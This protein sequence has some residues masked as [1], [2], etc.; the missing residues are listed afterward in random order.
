MQSVARTRL[1]LAIICLGSLLAPFDTTVNTAFPVITAAFSLPLRDIQWV[2]IPFVLAQSSFA[3]IFGHLGDRFGH[4]RIF[5]LG[6]GASVLAHAAV[7]LAP[8]FPTMV[9]MRMFQ[10]A[11]VGIAVSCGPALA[12]LLYAPADKARV[13]SLYIAVGSVA[14]AAGP[15]LGGLLIQTLGWPGVYWFR[16]PVALVALLLLPLVPARP[17][18]AVS[19]DAARA[20]RFDWAGAIGLTAV[21]TCLV[22]GLAELTRP[23]AQAGRALLLLA[24]GGAGAV[25]WVRHEG[26]AAHPVLR[27]T[28]FRSAR[29]SGIQVASVVINLACFANLLLLPYLLTGA[30]GA[31][32]GSA[33]LMLSM[34]PGGSVLGSLLA[35]RLAARWPAA[36]L[37]ALG[38]ATSAVGLLLTAVVLA[39]MQAP[40]GPAPIPLAIGMLVSGLGL[41][42]FQVGY[43]EAT[44]SMLPIEERGVAGSLVGVTR[45]MGILLGA[46][47]ISWLQGLTRDHALT[48]SLLSLALGAGALL[49][50][51]LS[52]RSVSRGRS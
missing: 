35:G 42:L 8:D 24:A 13:L 1:A 16:V 10:G 27:M 7:A 47:G 36:R 33:G 5:A 25:L 30:A 4:R 46:T 14:M 21:L 52:R 11:A 51:A 9:A 23:G 50:S 2:V 22:L 32:L 39:V 41:G 37:M 31:S 43:M 18:L 19:S 49:F 12:T 45:L 29:F 28:P 34:Y 38:L 26:R 6:L 15:W 17:R 3:L 48:F 40:A 20:A 44:T